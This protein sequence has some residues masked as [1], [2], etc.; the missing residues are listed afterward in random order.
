M[1]IVSYLK[2]G[3]L[4]HYKTNNIIIMIHHS[5]IDANEIVV[6]VVWTIF[7]IK[8]ITI[9]QISLFHF[10][11]SLPISYDIAPPA[12]LPSPRL[13][14]IPEHKHFCTCPPTSFFFSTG[15]QVA[16]HMRCGLQRTWAH[17]IQKDTKKDMKKIIQKSLEPHSSCPACL[18][19]A[20]QHKL[21][22]V[23]S[24]QAL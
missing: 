16:Y 14:Y 24:K 8:L 5:M 15:L 1:Y 22:L 9:R 20:K 23:D 19:L 4:L 17:D 10:A 18:S 12:L 3:I 6:Q 11:I 21:S 2:Y 13:S 7:S